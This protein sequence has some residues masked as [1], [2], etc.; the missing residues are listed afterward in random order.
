MRELSL[1]RGPPENARKY[2]N[3]YCR[4]PPPTKGTPS[5]GIIPAADAEIRTS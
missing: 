4:T 1:T 5:F 2:D 3:P